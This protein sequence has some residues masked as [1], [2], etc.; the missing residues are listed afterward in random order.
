MLFGMVTIP[1]AVFL[2]GTTVLTMSAVSVA[3][4]LG[5]GMQPRKETC[6]FT[7][8][9]AAAGGVAGKLIFQKIVSLFANLSSAG[10][11]QESLLLLLNLTVLLLFCAKKHYKPLE[12]RGAVNYI[13]IGLVLG[14]LSSFLGIGG[15]PLNIIVLYCFF[16]MENAEA[17]VNSLYI[18]FF[19]QFTGTLWTIISG[20]LPS[21][22][23][24]CLLLMIS[25]GVLG[26][27]G[28]KFVSSVLREKARDRVF[29]LV[30]LVIICINMYNMYGYSRNL[31]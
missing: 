3:G 6:L 27:F 30:V 12:V 15:G 23:S 22:D 5:K 17:V 31:S 21:F 1:E 14:L 7:A 20:A 25:G 19:S 26:A 24:R 28:G 16:S 4:S 9:G 11:V 10:L 18:I 2:S 13:A 8:S 29:V